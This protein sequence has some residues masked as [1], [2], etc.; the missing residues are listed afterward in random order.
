MD[1]RID[2]LLFAIRSAVEASIMEAGKGPGAEDDF[3][4]D[5]AWAHARKRLVEVLE[6]LRKEKA[7]D[8]VTALRDWI[9]GLPPVSSICPIAV[10]D[11]RK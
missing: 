7:A 5:Q 8:R 1:K 10:E 4:E 11:L 2:E 3:A 9:D 6:E